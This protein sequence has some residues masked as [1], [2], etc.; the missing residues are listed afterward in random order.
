M[1]GVAGT[2]AWRPFTYWNVLG[3]VYVYIKMSKGDIKLEVQEESVKMEEEVPEPD[4]SLESIH[5]IGL[6][7]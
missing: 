4:I 7:N 6:A 3:L 2:I 5:S 1:A